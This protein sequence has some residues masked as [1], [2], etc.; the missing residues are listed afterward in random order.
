MSA[1]APRPIAT[2]R[3][4]L[5]GPPVDPLARHGFRPPVVAQEPDPTVLNGEE[6]QSTQQTAVAESGAEGST[7]ASNTDAAAQPQIRGRGALGPQRAFGIVGMGKIFREQVER[8]AAS[9]PVRSLPDHWPRLTP[10]PQPDID[11]LFRRTKAEPAIY[12]A[13]I[14][15]EEVRARETGPWQPE[16][17]GDV[18]DN[19]AGRGGRPGKSKQ[20]EEWERERR[21]RMMEEEAKKKVR[22]YWV[23]VSVICNH[24]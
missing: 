16:V 8:A 7:P 9:E 24:H 12:W 20:D 13:P 4:V 22:L 2:Q 6:N 1:P 21:R 10:P 14:L 11:E 3:V 15:D 23:C 17:V 5:A 18:V 19:R